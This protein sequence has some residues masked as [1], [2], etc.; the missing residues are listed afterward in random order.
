METQN[1]TAFVSYFFFNTFYRYGIN[2]IMSDL[3]LEPS[4]GRLQNFLHMNDENFQYLLDLISP[5][6]KK[7]RYLVLKKRNFVSPFTLSVQLV[8]NF[9]IQM[10]NSFDI[11]SKNRSVERSVTK[12]ERLFTNKTNWRIILQVRFAVFSHF[13][14][15]IISIGKKTLPLYFFGRINGKKNDFLK[16]K[17]KNNP[18]LLA[19]CYVK[20]CSYSFSKTKRKFIKCPYCCINYIYKSG[21]R[22]VVY[23]K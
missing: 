17:M 14:P 9:W 18:I 6:I 10:K 4:S 1:Q 11:S 20:L 2:A 7:K 21:A 3:H 19:I 5:Q 22:A 16:I 12:R 15:L 13:R 23:S 8:T